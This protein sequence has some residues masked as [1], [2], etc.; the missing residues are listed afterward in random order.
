M[1]PIVLRS[2]LYNI[3]EESYTT[4]S[5][6]DIFNNT[7]KKS[8]HIENVSPEKETDFFCFILTDILNRLV[9]FQ[10]NSKNI[11]LKMV[12]VVKDAILAHLKPSEEVAKL[13]DKLEKTSEQINE[14]VEIINEQ[15]DVAN[16]IDYYP[17]MDVKVIY[18]IGETV[19]KHIEKAWNAIQ[20]VIDLF[21]IIGNDDMYKVINMLITKEKTDEVL[22]MH[23][24]HDNF[25]EF[26][27]SF[28]KNNKF[29]TIF[30]EIEYCCHIIATFKELQ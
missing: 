4:Q 16:D 6:T 20:E 12:F 22:M 9:P 1:D 26:L 14:F 10:S 15:L 5:R 13:V 29:S 11:F 24:I 8:F 27:Q 28:E 2:K 7:S 30:L 19:F 21:K 18:N 17:T 25:L 23:K 3:V